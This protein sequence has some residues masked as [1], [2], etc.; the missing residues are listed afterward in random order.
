MAEW[1]LVK[2]T[3]RSTLKQTTLTST[4]G[5]HYTLLG[6]LGGGGTRQW[7]QSEVYLT[8]PCGTVVRLLFR[9]VLG[10][11]LQ[12]FCRYTVCLP[13]SRQRT[14]KGCSPPHLP[15]LLKL[16]KGN[17]GKNILLTKFHLCALWLRLHTRY[18]I[19]LKEMGQFYFY[20]SQEQLISSSK[21][22]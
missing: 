2:E 3:H 20:L 14:F 10:K 16:Q 17:T 19:I 18:S 12:G 13:H 8:W 9:P 15:F 22:T 7:G 11:M 4:A 6:G 1:R 21:T 5:M